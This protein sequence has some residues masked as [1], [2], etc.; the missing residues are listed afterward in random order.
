MKVP[1]L[2]LR[3][4]GSKKN[5]GA[6]TKDAQMLSEAG[7]H[8]TPTSRKLEGRG[9]VWRGKI[10]PY[11]SSVIL[12]IGNER[13]KTK[14]RIETG[15][16]R[17]PHRLRGGGKCREKEDG[18]ERNERRKKTRGAEGSPF[19]VKLLFKEPSANVRKLMLVP[20]QGG[21]KGS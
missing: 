15:G 5:T 4:A 9:G 19:L 10:V 12:P 20:K 16:G 21:K 6:S 11:R 14:K 2:T 17:N 7:N 3:K 1:A 13:E 18:E 8:R